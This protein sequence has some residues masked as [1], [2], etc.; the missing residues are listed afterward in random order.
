MGLVWILGGLAVV[1]YAVV[2]PRWDLAWNLGEAVHLASAVAC[3][4]L[5]LVGVVVGVLAIVGGVQMQR[6]A[7]TRRPG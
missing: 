3:G 7:G 6:P 4:A 1:A 5:G 2:S